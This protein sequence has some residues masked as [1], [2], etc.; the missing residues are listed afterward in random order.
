MTI[1]TKKHTV[2]LDLTEQEAKELMCL[3]GRCG[4]TVGELLTAF[5]S[6][7]VNSD[8]RHGSDE[9]DLASAWY[10]RCGFEIDHASSY[11]TYLLTYGLMDEF[12]YYYDLLPSLERELADEDTTDEEREEIQE[13]VQ[14]VKDE[15]QELWNEYLAEERP[16]PTPDYESEIAKILEWII[17]D[18]KWQYGI[19]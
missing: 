3:A 6:D 8:R 19:S 16:E 10:N 4:F 9:R 11:L 13:D 7:L 14:D 1:E 2:G 5:V 12:K 15:I 18:S 17:Q